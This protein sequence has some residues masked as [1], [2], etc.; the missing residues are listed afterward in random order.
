MHRTVHI[1]RVAMNDV[2]VHLVGLLGAVGVQLDAV[3]DTFSSL[4]IALE[5]A[6][7]PDTRIQSDASR[8][9]KLQPAS[10]PFGLWKGKR[11]I[12][13]LLRAS[14]A[15]DA[16]VWGHLEWISVLAFTA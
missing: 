5:G 15:H 12:A 7:V 9:R 2:L 4:V 13:G 14:Q 11:K 6:T 1:K 10:N 8:E 3:S 16:S